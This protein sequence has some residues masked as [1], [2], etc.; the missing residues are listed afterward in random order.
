M[1]TLLSII[2][3]TYNCAGCLN[4]CLESVLCQ[5]PVNA[6]LL[7]VDD[8]SDEETLRLLSAYEG[9][10][11]NLRIFYREHKGASGARNTGLENARG[12]FVAFLDCDDRLKKDFLK[13]SLPLL[14]DSLPLSE[15][16]ADLYIF[17]IE[18]I[19][20]EGR[21]ERMTVPDRTYPD[22]S[23]FADAYIR[24]RKLLIYS[25]CN[26]FYRRSVIA[27]MKLM[28][29]ENVQFGEDRL[30]NY[31]FLQG[32][33]K[34]ITSSRIMLEYVQRSLE[35]MSARHIPGLFDLLLNL[36][37]RKM[38]CFLSLARDTSEEERQ[39]F[40]RYD[41]SNEI[42]NLMARFPQHPEE[43]TENLPKI[44]TLISDRSL[45]IELHP[46]FNR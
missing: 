25:N 12:E 18:R 5:L 45:N 33:G 27:E 9:R 22:A 14:E 41:L 13:N 46:F 7:V 28:F 6:E 8:G 11:D 4:E 20:L 29:D 38:D 37:E 36:H 3:P 40:I 17:G 10:Q 2:I 1:N 15:K 24:E 42:R 44:R 39:L 35:S 34:V 21:A 32:C 26:K 19:P 30:F 23:S 16:T 43:E 31:G